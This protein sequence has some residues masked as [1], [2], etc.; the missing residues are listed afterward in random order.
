MNETTNENIKKKKYER[1]PNETY[2]TVYN[3]YNLSYFKK[4]SSDL[5]NSFLIFLV[6]FLGVSY[7][8]IKIKSDDIVLDWN[9]QKCKPGI[10]P[11]AGII[12]PPKDGSSATDFTI[13]N[14]EECMNN[15]FSDLANDAMLPIN[16]VISMVQEL[17]NLIKEAINAIRQFVDYIRVAAQNIFQEIMGK[18]LNVFVSLQEFMISMKDLFAKVQGIMTGVL[19]L[20]ISVYYTMKSS[21]GAF[22]ELIIIILLIM[23][24]IIIVLW[25]IPVT[26]GVAAA[27]LVIFLAI[28]I[29]LAIIAGVMAEAFDLSLSGMPGAPTC[30]G[31]KTL[32]EMNDG[33]FKNIKYIKPG[34]KLKNNNVV[35]N[36]LKCLSKYENFY[37]INNTI[38]SGSH[39]IFK[40]NK[41]IKVEDYENKIKED[42]K[43]KY[44]YCLVTS[45]KKIEI[46]G[47]IYL[48]FDD[49]KPEK[50]KNIENINSY[51]DGGIEGYS[52]IKLRNGSKKMIKDIVPGDIL[53]D[54][55]VVLGLVCLD[56]RNIANRNYYILNNNAIHENN[57]FISDNEKKLI[58]SKNLNI[59]L[60]FK[61]P[62]LYHLVTSK[63]YFFIENLQLLHYSEMID[64]YIK[65]YN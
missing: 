42:Y 34:E 55:V 27:G 20:S 63:G 53:Y 64:I 13:N 3:L 23:A 18:L 28:S 59:D 12:N 37:K 11:F 47:E 36:T 5:T 15:I 35:L 43:S 16:F 61:E 41:S 29:P 22:Y 62:Y 45:S 32:I 6:I 49:V 54:D 21:I 52:S 58:K 30:F 4:Y 14:F 9:N 17:F 40:N 46:D 25:I 7:N 39:Y 51:V 38:V 57:Y 10:M 44:S 50:T 60:N 1:I 2:K 33:S 26:W 65:N 8:Y 19:Y 56:K 24:A 48:D 31:H